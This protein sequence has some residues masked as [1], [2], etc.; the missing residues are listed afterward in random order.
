MHRAVVIAVASSILAI[1][2]VGLSTP[3]PNLTP[4]PTAAPAPTLAPSAPTSAPYSLA[5]AS[6][7]SYA[8]PDAT[9]AHTSA[10]GYANPTPYY[11]YSPYTAD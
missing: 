6:A 7:Y 2:C 4:T 11:D 3:T 5:H 1:A 9:D 8:H 10:Y